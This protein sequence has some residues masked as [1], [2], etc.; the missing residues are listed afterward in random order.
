MRHQLPYACKH[1][2]I[3]GSPDSP[4][5]CQDHLRDSC[6]SGEIE[7]VSMRGR[8]KRCHSINPSFKNR[9]RTHKNVVISVKVQ[10]FSAEGACPFPRPL[11]TGEEDT[12]CPDST[13]LGSY[14]RLA[15]S[16]SMDGPPAS[17]YLP[18][19]LYEWLHNMSANSYT[20]DFKHII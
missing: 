2:G 14:R 16:L 6:R 9:V 8:G 20:N 5:R 3:H 19:R 7:V 18:P 4:S 10:F 15:S 13:S 17:L 12:P 11:P 1:G